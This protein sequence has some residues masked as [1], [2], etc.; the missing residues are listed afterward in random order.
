MRCFCATIL[1]TILLAGSAT[2]DLIDGRT[3]L[4]LQLG[5]QKLVG[6]DHDYSNVD[7]NFGLWLRRGTSARWSLE[8]GLNYGWVRPGADKGQDAGFT[9]DS[10]H[11]FYTTMTSAYGGMRY[12]FA[13]ASRFGPYAGFQLGLTSWNVRDENFN[14][15]GLFP[16]GTTVAVADENGESV[17]LAGTNAT[18]ALSLGA[19]YFISD[20]FS[21]DIGARYALLFG[22]EMDNIGSSAIWALSEADANTRRW[23]LFLGGTLY[24][25]GSRDDDGD[26]I[27][28]DRDVCPDA[29][30]DFDGYR[31]TDGCPEWDNDGD[32]VADADDLCP[33]DPEDLDGFR[34]GDGCPDPDNDGDGVIDARDRCPDVA[35]DEDGF[36]DADGC[37]DVDDDGDGVLD[38]VD[39]CPD[40][41]SGVAVGADGCP[42]VAEIQAA[43]VLEGVSFTTNSAQLTFESYATLNKVAESLAAYPEVLV[44]IQGHTD[45][46]GSAAYNLDI[47]GRRAEAVKDY[48]VSQGIDPER[49]TAVGYGEDLPIA[50][51]ET[52]EGRAA[53]RRVELVRR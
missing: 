45:R 28:N 9:F 34:D 46:T 40:T 25:G 33:D 15:V 39:S 42:V 8:L 7:Q 23:D 30:E 38:T 19:E 18:G 37:P 47:S 35:E 6:G 3:G 20:S 11:A 24:F 2:A 12:H 21:L 5:M 41:P 16:G 26:G 44:E 29:A 52:R 27:E 50:S 1:L 10:V 48:L 13:P 14:D 49:L 51:N 4:G 17:R 22:N 36:E 31:D 43:M 53:N 32:G